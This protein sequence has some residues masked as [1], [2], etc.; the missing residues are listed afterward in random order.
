[1]LR[2]NHQLYFYLKTR[3]FRH[4][5]T[6]VLGSTANSRQHWLSKSRHLYFTQ[7]DFIFI[8]ILKFRER[9][10]RTATTFFSNEESLG[11]EILL[12]G[13]FRM[14]GL[15]PKITPQ[16]EKWI[17]L[18]PT[19]HTLGMKKEQWTK[20]VILRAHGNNQETFFIYFT[21]Q[22]LFVQLETWQQKMQ[23]WYSLHYGIYYIYII[24]YGLMLT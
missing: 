20:D 21:D 19:V 6:L 24:L 7:D 17:Q 16:S 12:S 22:N 5:I 18:L 11:I 2:L 15:Y 23:V 3:F 1:M 13:I 14:S 4:S 8:F 10:M 9:Q